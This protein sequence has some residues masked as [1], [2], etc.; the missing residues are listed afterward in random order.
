MIEIST[1]RLF[2]RDHK[3][4]DIREYHRLISDPEVMFFLPDLLSTSLLFSQK[5]LDEAI[6]ESAMGKE[7][8][9]YFFAIFLKTGEYVGEIGYTVTSKDRENGKSVHLGYFSLKVYWGK[10]IMSEA[11]KAVVDYAFGRGNVVKV[12]TG[13]LAGNKGSEKVMIK[14]GFIREAYKKSHQ[15]L[16][17]KWM[18]RVEYGLVSPN[19]R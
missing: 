6:T 10:G 7:R 4:E 14:A 3:P 17:G 9:K 12:E 1:E 5:S 19:H 15:F 2:I 16:G 11:V 13:C 8:T 18:D